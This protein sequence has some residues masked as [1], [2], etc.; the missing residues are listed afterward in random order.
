MV[1]KRTESSFDTQS[2]NQNKPV[3]QSDTITLLASYKAM[4]KSIKQTI[5]Q[6]SFGRIVPHS[7]IGLAFVEP[8][9]LADVSRFA[10]LTKM[11]ATG[12]SRFLRSAALLH[13]YDFEASI[14]VVSV[15]EGF[16]LV[17]GRKAFVFISFPS[18]SW[19]DSLGSG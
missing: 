15:L 12:V 13:K 14:C 5:H 2:N 11:I 18:R 10:V 19:L 1:A 17:T 9:D 7:F 4:S 6:H 16:V 8:A 3:N